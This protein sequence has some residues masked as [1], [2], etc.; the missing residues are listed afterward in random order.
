MLKKSLLGVAL[1]AVLAFGSPALAAPPGPTIV[2]TAIAVNAA[3]GEFSILIAA[4][5]AADP[6][7]L[8]TL[9]GNG[10]FTVFAPTDAA[11]LALLEE[12]SLEADDILGNEPLLT[13]VLLYHVS[14]GRRASTNVV[15]A[16]QVRMLN[17]GFLGQSGGVLTDNQ[18][19]QARIVG[20]DVFAA[21]GVI[22]VIDAVVLP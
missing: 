14:Q 5:T 18:G 20:P 16:K 9:S 4:L 17:G 11:F 2:D 12:L 22:H 10:Q 8:E 3:T 21:N 13:E 15:R 19:R 1:V 7:V 6:A